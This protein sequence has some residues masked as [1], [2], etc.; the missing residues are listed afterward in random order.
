MDLSIVIVNWNTKDLLD[1]CLESIYRTITIPSF[2]VW[3]VDNASSDDSV[4]MVRA[5]YPKVNLLANDKNEGFGRANNQ[6]M[7]ASSGKNILL[8]NSDILLTQGAVDAVWER[9]QN[10]P[11]IGVLGC[12]LVGRDGLPQGNWY[13][14]F[15]YGPSL[16]KNRQPLSDGMVEATWVWAA[17]EMVRR[18]VIEQVGG[19]DE[20]FFIFYEDIDWSWRVRDAGWI[21]ACDLTV[22]VIHGCSKS[23][24]LLPDATYIR[25][26]LVSE[27]MLFYKHHSALRYRIWMWRRFLYYHARILLYKIVFTLTHKKWQFETVEYMQ[28]ALP[29]LT[30]MRNPKNLKTGYRA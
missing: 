8:L 29:V 20:D 10:H 16:S 5:K 2:D 27:Y 7:K 1:E 12:S 21:I 13:T 3:V 17:F 22:K 6:A 4:T 23:V 11:K 30:E 28:K 15:L 19:F 9:F 24:K 18:E 26:R 14:S 25:W